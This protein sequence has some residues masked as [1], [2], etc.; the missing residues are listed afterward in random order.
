MDSNE[1][2]NDFFDVMSYIPN[3][4]Q[5]CWKDGLDMSENLTGD[6]H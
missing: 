1:G 2:V 6:G 3:V 5:N 4:N